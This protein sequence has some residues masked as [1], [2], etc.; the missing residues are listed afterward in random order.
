MLLGFENLDQRWLCVQVRSGWE[1]R[2]ALGLKER[3][4][5]HFVPTF[6]Q[7]REW[8]DRTKIVEVPLFTGYLFLRFD[9]RNDHPVVT[10]P[11][12]IRFVGT[13]KMPT[14]IDNAEIEALQLATRAGLTCG[15][16]A[17]LAVGQEIEIRLGP[18]ASLRGKIVRFKDKQRLILSVNLIQ[19]SVF[20]E[21]DGYEVTPV[22]RSVA[23]SHVPLEPEYR[24]GPAAV[25]LS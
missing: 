6:K 12:V 22:S 16:C 5:E 2:S 20:V 24:A 19:K 21:I 17:F 13:G 11:G 8:S 10:V 23:T 3:G 7:K 15:P 25:P 14:P 4:Y 9:A 18:L 1:F